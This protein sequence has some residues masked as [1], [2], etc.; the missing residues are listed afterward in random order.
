[1][2]SLEPF[3]GTRARDAMGA[4]ADEEVAHRTRYGATTRAASDD[5]GDG[6]LTRGS[7]VTTTAPAGARVKRVLWVL[8]LAVSAIVAV[9]ATLARE[10][11]VAHPGHG[12]SH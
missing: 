6:T 12:R 9:W 2:C 8:A 7:W 10:S 3:I 1:V 4:N 5:D 11:G